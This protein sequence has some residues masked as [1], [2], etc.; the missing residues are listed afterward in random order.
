M[1]PLNS[2]FIRSSHRRPNRRGLSSQSNASCRQSLERTLARLWLLVVN[3]HSAGPARCPKKSAFGQY[4]NCSIERPIVKVGRTS[5]EGTS[6]SRLWRSFCLCA[7]LPAV[8]SAAMAQTNA[9]EYSVSYGIN[10]SS[11]DRKHTIF[12][13]FVGPASF[14]YRPWCAIAIGLDDDTFVSNKSSTG[15]SNGTGD[16][17]F[18]AHITMWAGR[19]NAVSTG[20]CRAGSNSSVK[21]D[22]IVTVPV[23]GTLEYTELVHQVKLS[24]NRP[25]G[26]GDLF[27]NVGIVIS[28]LSSGGTTQ[29]ALASANYSRSFRK[30]SVWMWEAEA[31]LQSASKV[32]PSSVSPLLALDASFGKNQAWTL[33]F[34]ASPGI[35]PYAPKITPFVQINFAGSMKRKVPNII[36]T[37]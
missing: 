34:G 20:D 9:S 21:V 24:Y 15:R 12:P 36:F 27:V 18:E 8:T 35:T 4:R 2:C 5:S 11:A 30:G 14:I 1:P 10:Y 13:G 6:L 28:G 22:Y 29:N 23:P 7:L 3:T 19:S 33:R 16:L 31:D 26:L 17:G 37:E 32:A 25:W